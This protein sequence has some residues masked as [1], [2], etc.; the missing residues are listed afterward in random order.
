MTTDR[1]YIWEA[2]TCDCPNTGVQK[3]HG[4]FRVI[5]SPDCP[6]DF[7]EQVSAELHR[8]PP[9]YKCEVCYG[10]CTR[11][12]QRDAK[13]FAWTCCGLECCVNCHQI[14]ADSP[15]MEHPKQHSQ[16]ALV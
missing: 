10:G 1:D 11:A 6:V 16:K 12:G 3:G 8:N 15:E 5:H 13:P 7:D 14:A 2:L 9:Q 4:I